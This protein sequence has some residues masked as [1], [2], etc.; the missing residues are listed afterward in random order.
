[1]S[2]I[3]TDLEAPKSISAIADANSEKYD[4][5]G[6]VIY[7]DDSIDQ[8]EGAERVRTRPEATLGS[9]GLSGARHTVIEIVGNS[10]DEANSG[11]G[12]RLDV[13]YHE[14]RSVSIRDY[15][16]GVPMGYNEKRKRYN[17]DLIYNEMYAG[18]KYGDSQKK[19]AEFDWSQKLDLVS[20]VRQFNYLLSVGLNGLG[21]ACTQ[22]TSEYFEVRS[23]RK[24]KCS[25]MKFKGGYPILPTE[26][27][28]G[29]KLSKKEAYSQALQITDTDELDGTYI[30]WKPDIEV[31][32]DVDIKAD[33][34]RETVGDM[35][36]ISGVELHY[37]NELTGESEVVESGGL[38]QLL[39]DKFKG[40]IASEQDEDG[41]Y[42]C[43]DIDEYTHGHTMH[44]NKQSIYVL[45]VQ[46]KIVPVKK[47]SLPFCFHNSVPTTGGAQHDGIMFAIDR[48]FSNVVTDVKVERRDYVD[49]LGV[50]LSSFSNI[51]SYKGQTKSEVDNSFIQEFC[52]NTVYDTLEKEYHKGTKLITDIVKAVKEEAEARIAIKEY[53]KQ[54]RQAKKSTR[55]KPPEKFVSCINYDRKNYD[56]VELWLTE[57]DSAS[58]SCKGARDRVFQALLPVRGKL[59]NVLKSNMQKILSNDIIRNIFSVLGVVMDIGDSLFNI[60]DLKVGKIIIATD[61]DEDGYQIRVLLFLVFYKLAPELLRQG[62]VF[63]AETPL[64]STILPNGEKK[65]IM[66]K[67]DLQELEAKYGRLKTQRFKGLG[68]SNASEL[69]ETTLDPQT[70]TLTPLMIDFEDDLSI[71]II[72]SLFG[73]DDAKQRKSILTNILGGSTAELLEENMRKREEIDNLDIDDGVEYIV[74]E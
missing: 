6:D 24:G 38:N 39:K 23:Y 20:F 19:L 3:N 63:I 22:Y 45:F 64:Y 14:D 31:F 49:K 48:F 9:D 65:F 62:K 33:W 55:Q 57:G 37:K 4:A 35:L 59:L 34:L 25:S 67:R 50:V 30:H 10:L 53:E 54:V 69:K 27:A 12:S 51:V 66:T 21:G 26:D 36:Q 13:T 18:G 46:A 29:N 52:Y 47:E 68:E 2:E 74:V 58:T 70:R 42:A 60:D 15:G 61:A 41:N 7:D 28:D 56:E 32:S 17:W 8:L 16:R 40:N 72:N 44:R 71:S 73:T 5:N 43:I 1:M 11:Y